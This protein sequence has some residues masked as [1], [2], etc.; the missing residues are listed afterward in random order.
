MA[1]TVK[2][3]LLKRPL[4]DDLILLKCLQ[5]SNQCPDTLRRVEML[6][7]LDDK[8]TDR[9]FITTNTACSPSREAFCGIGQISCNCWN[10]MGRLCF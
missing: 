8:G 9:V 2:K 10:T 1:C 3:K 7:E 5:S 4:R 6:V